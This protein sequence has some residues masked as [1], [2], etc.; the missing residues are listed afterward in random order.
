MLKFYFEM[1]QNEPLFCIDQIRSLCTII[2]CRSSSYQLCMDIH[3]SQV[4][5]STTYQLTEF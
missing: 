1:I 3:P 4:G 5:L 2:I